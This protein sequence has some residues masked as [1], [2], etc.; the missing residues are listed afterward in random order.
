[1]GMRKKIEVHEEHFCDECGTTTEPVT[2]CHICKREL[3]R[4]D[5]VEI[6]AQ[7][8]NGPRYITAVCFEH[9]PPE[10]LADECKR[11]V[12]IV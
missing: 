3:C 7:A 12:K 2:Q 11:M 8:V 10:F 6:S 4:N 9:V 5:R 1:M